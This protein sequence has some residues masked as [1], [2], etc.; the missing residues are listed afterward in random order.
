MPDAAKRPCRIC[1]RWF[2]PDIRVGGRQRVCGRPECQAT[3]RKQNNASWLARNPGYFVAL[4]IQ[5]RAAPEPVRLPSPLSKLPWDLAQEEFGTKGA[6]FIGAMGKVLLE[7][8]KD[9][10]EGSTC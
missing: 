2:L 5:A 3:R 9:Q 4:R 7:S 10:L 1:R 6:D 8:A